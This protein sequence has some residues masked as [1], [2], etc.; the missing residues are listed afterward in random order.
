MSD[1]VEGAQGQPRPVNDRRSGVVGLLG[2]LLALLVVV[3]SAILLYLTVPACGIRLFGNTM[4]FPWCE[5]RIAALVS[6]ETEQERRSALENQIHNAELALLDPNLCGPPVEEAAVTPPPEADEPSEDQAAICEPDQVFQPAEEV[7]LV[8][9]GSGSMRFAAD[10]PEQLLQ[11]YANVRREEDRLRS[12]GPSTNI[13]EQFSQVAALKTVIDRIEDIE[14]RMEQIPGSSRAE[15]ARETLRRT[16]EGAPADLP[17]DLTIFVDCEDI[18]SESYGSDERPELLGRISRLTP[19]QGTPLAD[20][21]RIAARNLQGGDDPENPVTMVVISDGDDSCGG[22]P[23]AAA[24]QIKAAKP[25]LIINL[26]DLS[27]N[28]KLRCVAEATGGKFRRGTG[29]VDELTQMMQES[30][31]Y[32]GAG[33][34]R[35]AAVSDSDAANAE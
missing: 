12:A 31:G 14:Q 7:A 27:Q 26:V 11:E 25:G 30:A 2:W 24:R 28:D 15:V 13:F 16:V 19:Q 35:P 5:P 4:I 9:D 34:C 18:V 29:N 22:D 3:V 17:I 8:I 6:L 1:A 33:Q 32:R 21:M 23:C 10:I 20:A